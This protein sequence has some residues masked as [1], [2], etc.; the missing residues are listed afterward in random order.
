MKQLWLP[1]SMEVDLVEKGQ[2][3]NVGAMVLLLLLSHVVTLKAIRLV[4]ISTQQ[5][6]H[7][8][9]SDGDALTLHQVPVS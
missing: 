4:G 3:E 5:L 2:S 1:K 6:G 9:Y 7:S 8:V